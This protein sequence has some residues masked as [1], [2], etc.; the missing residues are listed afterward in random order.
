MLP[1]NY[2]FFKRIANLLKLINFKLY[3]WNPHYRTLKIKRNL[4]KRKSGKRFSCVFEVWSPFND[5]FLCRRGACVCVSIRLGRAWMGPEG[6]RDCALPKI[7]LLELLLQT[8][9]MKMK[10]KSFPHSTADDVTAHLLISGVFLFKTRMDAASIHCCCCC[11]C[12]RRC[13]R[14]CVINTASV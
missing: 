2:F 12:C 14:C 8:E 9:L 4:T 5:F 7:G 1:R 11:C 10:M 13:C 6:G 3:K